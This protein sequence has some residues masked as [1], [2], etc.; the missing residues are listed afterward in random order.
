MVALSIPSFVPPPALIRA[1]DTPQA[2]LQH[3]AMVSSAR[4]A[5]GLKEDIVLAALSLKRDCGLS[6]QIAGE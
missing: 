1:L 4:V 2:E 5:H 6:D 3:C